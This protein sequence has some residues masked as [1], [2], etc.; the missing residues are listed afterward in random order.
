[1]SESD[2]MHSSM[3]A[4]S[5]SGCLVFRNNVGLFL[6]LDGKRRVFCGL[7][8][9]SGDIV[10]IKPT[11]ITEDMVGKTL[12]I[13]FNVESKKP[14]HKTSKERK[15]SQDR[16]ID[17][18]RRAGGLAGYAETAEQALGVIGH[19]GD[20]CSGGEGGAGRTAPRGKPK[21]GAGT[22]DPGD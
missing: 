18:V 22:N 14:K 10:G 21:H 8:K 5:A 6:T 2:V 16:F 9:G 15:E 12:G 13:F 20:H 19:G 7:A 11:I 1:M 17:A 4:L 3:L